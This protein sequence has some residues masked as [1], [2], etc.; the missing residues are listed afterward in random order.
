MQ[1]CNVRQWSVVESYLLPLESEGPALWVGFDAAGVVRRG[2][3]QY[4]HQALQRVLNR[5]CTEKKNY[6]DEG[7]KS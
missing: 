3:V 2:A 5:A 4:L 1:F 7:V 6:M